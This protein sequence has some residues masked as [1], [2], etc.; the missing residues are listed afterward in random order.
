MSKYTIPTHHPR[1]F[2]TREELQ[3]LAK[4]RPEFYRRVANC[5]R[6]NLGENFDQAISMGLV[7][8]IEGD[9]DIGL[10]ALE[11]V[12]PWIEGPLNVGHV[13]WGHDVATP[14]FDL[15]HDLWTPSYKQ[16]FFDWANRNR[17]ANLKEENHVFHNSYYASR[18]FAVGIYALATWHENPRAEEIFAALDEDLR[19]RGIPALKK[20]G[21]GGG[22]GEG[23][24]ITYFLAEFLTFCEA[25]RRVAGID[26]YAMA[27]E[28]FSQRAIA[29]MFEMY[30]GLRAKGLREMIPL[31]DYGTRAY[32]PPRD[33]V[34][35]ARRILVNYYRSDPAHQA[36]HTF[37]N[38]TPTTVEPYYAWLDFLYNDNTVKEGDLQNFKLSHH[39]P[40]AGYVHARSSWKDD[41]AYF[42]FKCGP[43]FTSHQH[44]DNGHFLIFKHE[45]LLG[46]GGHFCD[47]GE[48]HSPNY[49]TRSI[50]HN[51]ILV[52][53]PD[54]VFKGIRNQDANHRNG[55]DGGQAFPWRHIHV[56]GG[57]EDM[58]VWNQNRELLETGEITAYE[59]QGSY[60][61]V[62]GDC[63]KSYSP[64]KLE[65][66]TRQI[67]FLRGD[68]A[69][70]FVIL[71]RVKSTNADFKKT[72]VLQALK[73]PETKGEDLVITHGKGR[74][75]VQTVLPTA[76][77]KTLH[78][79]DDLYAYGGNNYPTCEITGPAPECR[80]EISP[81]Q[82]AKE[83]LFLHVM[84]ATTSDSNEVP[85]ATFERNGDEIIVKVGEKT[86]RFGKAA[87]TVT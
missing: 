67:V 40:G 42:F 4:K 45:E 2:G 72:F 56:N 12:R 79:G 55:N 80:I 46:D 49:Y 30:P 76:V 71:D 63:T 8:A 38:G 24:Y 44:L 5:A 22:W 86:V 78:Q 14:V 9:R 35:P 39:S 66:F 83:D 43:R 70:T 59:D 29:S 77:T 68:G 37:N 20:A 6:E 18:V 17:D 69:S 32:K 47:W 1:L 61:Y 75:F 28:F 10:K 64:K 53:D 52:H 48:V 50:A 34:N 85:R 81:T 74:L 13:H 73:I 60:L 25:A 65:S 51:T 54:E 82:P 41:A 11:L 33:R 7:Y 57:M 84:T 16:A 23:Y 19:R 31:Q 36:V 87:A 26:Y 62:A 15:C 3:A 27:P 58:D 21:N